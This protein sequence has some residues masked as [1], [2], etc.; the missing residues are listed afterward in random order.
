MLDIGMGLAAK[1]PQKAHAL[2][3]IVLPISDPPLWF[4][5]PSLSM[6]ATLEMDKKSKQQTMK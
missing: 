5:L 3:N 4:P 1:C 6:Q 2:V